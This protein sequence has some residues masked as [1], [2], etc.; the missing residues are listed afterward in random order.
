MVCDGEDGNANVKNIITEDFSV[1][2]PGK[3]LL[4]S[5]SVKISHGKRYGLVGPNGM[6]KC[7]LLKLL[8]WGKIL[9]PKRY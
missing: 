3:E 1:L 9:V 4:K 8:A 6:C 2:A 5:A 7:T